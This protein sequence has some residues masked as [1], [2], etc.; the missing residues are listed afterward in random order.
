MTDLLPNGF[1]TILQ[2][3][4]ALL[5]ALRGGMPERTLVR[6]LRDRG[7]DVSDGA[8]RSQAIEEI[9]KA[10]DAGRIRSDCCAPAA[11]GH[12][13]APPSPVMNSRRRIL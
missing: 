5:P 11:N 8:A 6:Q 12:T 3:A 1:L 7:L 13:A 2:A 9:W 10:V 4:D